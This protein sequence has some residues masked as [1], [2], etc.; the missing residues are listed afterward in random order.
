MNLKKR[1]YLRR[2]KFEN[3]LFS[4]CLA[5]YPFTTIFCCLLVTLILNVFLGCC[6]FY[7]IPNSVIYNVLF[8]LTTGVTTSCFVAIVVELSNNYKSNR[9][10][11]HELESYY[12]LIVAFERNKYIANKFM[13]ADEEHEVHDI[14]QLVWKDLPKMAPLL[15][16]TLEHKKAFLTDSEIKILKSLKSEYDGI[17]Y[18]VCSRM[19]RILQYNSLNHP[20]ED[21][22]GNKYPANVISDLPVWLKKY[23]AKKEC[24]GSIQQLTDII[25]TDDFLLVQIMSDYDISIQSMNR[26]DN[27]C[28]QDDAKVTQEETVSSE[29]LIY[30]Y[31]DMTEEEYKIWI[32][33][34]NKDMETKEIT[35]VSFYI[36]QSCFRIAKYIEELKKIVSQKPYV[37]V[38]LEIIASANKKV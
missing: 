9:L 5:L 13:N 25:M 18:E 15:L 8:T 22:I 2:Y 11:C 4:L 30:D 3:Y 34:I 38:Y 33:E 17:R 29:E 26:H 36:S 27:E 16:T 6:M 28:E 1:L 37:G 19:R 24:E 31:T 14:V 7:V 32:D 10:A 12:N 35:F 23:L 21:Y 20:D